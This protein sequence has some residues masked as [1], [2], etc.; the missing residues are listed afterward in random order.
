MKV[1]QYLQNR[2]I[3][4]TI[5]VLSRAL[6]FRSANHQVIS[7][8]MAN[9]DTPGYKVKKLLFDQELQRAAKTHA[10]RLKTTDPDHL[11]YPS[12]K[13]SGSFP[14][15]TVDTRSSGSNQLNLDMEMA[16]MMRNNLLYEA[17]AK[18][19]SKKF[20]ALRTAIDSGRR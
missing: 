10:V 20:N 14:V 6:D 9:I 2:F 11:S 16:K 18:L 7:G 3:G 15:Q 8:N 13:A 19:L 1:D 4:R 5:K 17:S 12:G